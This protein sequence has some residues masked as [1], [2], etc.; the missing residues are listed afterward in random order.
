MARLYLLLNF[1]INNFV[2]FERRPKVVEIILG[3]NVVMFF[4]SYTFLR[5]SP[6]S[7]IFGFLL[8]GAENYELVVSGQVWRM[9]TSAF[10]HA[11]IIH[12]VMNMYYFFQI[13]GI[14]ERFYGEKKFF[15]IYILTAILASIFSLA[16][17]VIFM[18]YSNISVGASGAIFGLLGLI[19]S[20]SWKGSRDPFHS[21]LPFD[22]KQL[23]PY[24]LINLAFGF[25][26]PGINNAAHIGGFIGG[27]VLGLVVRP[28]IGY[29]SGKNSILINLAFYISLGIL[30][31]SFVSLLLFNLSFF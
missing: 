24:V 4:I 11:N 22:Y 6:D 17:N 30:V 27:V 1:H 31:L 16:S 9:I 20:A 28:E 14:V 8:L 29:S 25:I 26:F 3:I 5:F 2:M 19:L 15:I 13:G 21:G 23:I 7:E 18:G 12:I 10:L